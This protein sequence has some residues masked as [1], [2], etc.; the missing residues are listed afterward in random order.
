MRFIFATFPAGRFF[1][2]PVRVQYLLL[3][4]LGALCL[5][6]KEPGELLA[7]W[8]VVALSVIF[9]EYGHILA[10]RT[11]GISA[12]KVLLTPIGGIATLS[13]VRAKTPAGTLFI[14]AAGPFVTALI[15]F[16]A[17]FVPEAPASV[18]SLGKLLFDVNF[19]L[20]VFNL[21][22]IYPMDGGRILAAL[23]EMAAA[24]RKFMGPVLVVGSITATGVAF[25]FFSN[26]MYMPGFLVLGACLFG[27]LEAK[28]FDMKATYGGGSKRYRLANADQSVVYTVQADQMGPGF[29]IDEFQRTITMREK[30]VFSCRRIE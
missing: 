19:M 13:S 5:Q 8:L 20:L 17:L 1:G 26:D 4:F 16:A 22:P 9:H 6:T 28:A 21:L 12:E 10:A 11:Q 14:A 27:F 2:V 15:A 24:G 29:D 25:F 30:Q 23:S 18:Q 7:A 3:V